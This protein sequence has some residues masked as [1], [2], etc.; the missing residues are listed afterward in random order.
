[1]MNENQGA[2]FVS[3]RVVTNY[4]AMSRVFAIESRYAAAANALI[5]TRQSPKSPSD[6][7]RKCKLIRH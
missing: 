5:H 6:N 7:K 1:M 3:I 4:K 2:L